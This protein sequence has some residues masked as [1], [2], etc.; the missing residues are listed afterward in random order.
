MSH[1]ANEIIKENL[2]QHFSAA[3]TDAEAQS[4]I[5]FTRS[6]GFRMLAAEMERRHELEEMYDQ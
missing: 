4:V 5:T 2:W 6:S 1:I 3:E